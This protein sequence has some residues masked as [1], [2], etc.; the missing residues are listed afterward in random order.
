M[1]NWFRRLTLRGKVQT[2]ILATTTLVLLL[3]F[4]FQALLQYV[5]L[6]QSVLEDAGLLAENIAARGTEPLLT[7]DRAAAKQVL[8]ELAARPNIVCGQFFDRQGNLLAGYGQNLSPDYHQFFQQRTSPS[9]H[10]KFY[11]DHVCLHQPVMHEGAWLG[12]LVMQASLLDMQQ[13]ML[14]FTATWGLTILAGWLFSWLL[15]RK[16]RDIISAP[17]ERLALAMKNVS[18][19]QNY[20]LRIQESGDPE[21]RQL[22][23]GFNDM[24]QQI[25]LRDSEL[26]LYRE[27]LDHMAH[28]DSLT[29]LPNRLLFNDRLKQ[30]IQRAERSKRPLALIFIDLDRFKN[31]NDTLGHDIGDL[32]L[33]EAAHRL[34]QSLR[35]SD[36]IARLGGDEFV[37]IL[38]DF[39]SQQSV[40]RIARK[41]INELSEECQIIDHRLYVTASL[42]ISFYPDNGTDLT[43]LKRCADIAMFRAKEMGRNNYQFYLPGM[44]DR[45]RRMLSLEGDLRE[46]LDKQQ[47]RLF[48]QPQ[49]SMKSGRVCGVE[50]LL[51]WEHPKQGI[52][53]PGEFI[54][55]AEETGLIVPLGEWAIRETCRM[56]RAWQKRDL[57]SLCFAVNVSPRQ[58]RQPNLVEMIQEILEETGLPPHLLELEVTETLLMSDVEDAIEKMSK[59]KELGIL[60][61]IDDFGSGYS[62]LSYLKHFPINKLKIDRSFIKD[63]HLDKNDLAIAASVASLAK[64]MELDALAEGVETRAQESAL[65]GLGMEWAQGFL[66]QKPVAP[67]QF[68]DFMRE[69]R[70]TGLGFS[71]AA[72]RSEQAR[73]EGNGHQD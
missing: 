63:L 16:F 25:E 27:R 13:G 53:L 57:P 8:R 52:I 49:V 37:V 5:E 31:I 24:L 30:A 12:T 38:E 50:A 56:A 43:T 48:L 6:K 60:L 44:G 35:R 4:L 36:T 66:Y 21:L 72:A 28:H 62:S 47:M 39:E 58:F 17:I 33:V 71:T 34:E 51:R 45:A 26:I 70:E 10:F 2:V 19:N 61:A 3:L 54:P 9:S 42:G 22:T 40:G 20:A 59:F 64:V 73:E 7:N 11:L 15:S 1:K 32:V 55:L 69:I 65:L 18:Q 23:N 46:A 41:I 68:E 14:H 29:G 67:E